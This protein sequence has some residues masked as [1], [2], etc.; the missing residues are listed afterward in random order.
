MS[1]MERISISL[2]S[3]LLKEFDEIID[4]KGYASR[5]E[6]IRDALRE[7]IL[8]YKWLKSLK[9]ERIGTIS[10]IYNHHAPEVM[11]KITDLQHEYRDVILANLHIHL[12]DE[13]CLEIIMVKGDAKR[14]VELKNKLNS[15]KGV[16]LAKLSVVAPATQI[17][18]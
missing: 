3:K 13:H 18:E 15:T 7:Y 1:D 12:D 5:S 14:I 8:R 4:E 9:G 2:P 16:K 17:P 11:E 10:I 6:A